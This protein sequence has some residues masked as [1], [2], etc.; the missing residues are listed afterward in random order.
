MHACPCQHSGNDEVV[1]V[2]T[3]AS[4][5]GNLLSPSNM[6]D[7]NTTSVS[8]GVVDSVAVYMVRI[9]SGCEPKT[10]IRVG[11]AGACFKQPQTEKTK[12]LGGSW[13]RLSMDATAG[14]VREGVEGD[15]V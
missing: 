15:S 10:K 8:G 7:T 6:V 2:S 11:D 14:R 9:R 13:N 1:P 5:L 12:P 4:A 3:A